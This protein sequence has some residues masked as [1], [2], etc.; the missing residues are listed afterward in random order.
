MKRDS[1]SSATKAWGI[2]SYSVAAKKSPTPLPSVTR[3]SW[4]GGRA[5]VGA[6]LGNTCDTRKSDRRHVRPGGPSAEVLPFFED[7]T[8]DRGRSRPPSGCKNPPNLDF[9]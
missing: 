7:L 8:M 6:T 5:S 2:A 3:D 1:G 9:L 4:S